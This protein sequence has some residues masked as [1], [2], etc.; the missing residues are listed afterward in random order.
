[1]HVEKVVV[2]VSGSMIVGAAV[3]LVLW[4]STGSRLWALV[5]AGAF[6]VGA[7]AACAPLLLLVLSKLLWEKRG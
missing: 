3:A 6:L 7:L 5:A 2:R 4:L 1:V